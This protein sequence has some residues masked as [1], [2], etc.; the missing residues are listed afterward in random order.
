MLEIPAF[1]YASQSCMVHVPRIA[2]QLHNIVPSSGSCSYPD[3]SLQVSLPPVLEFSTTYPLQIQNFSL[4]LLH[5]PI[6]INCM[7][8]TVLDCSFLTRVGAVTLWDD[9]SPS[10]CLLLTDCLLR[11]NIYDLHHPVYAEIQRSIRIVLDELYHIIVTNTM[12]NCCVKVHA[13]GKETFYILKLCYIHKIILNYIIV[14]IS[15]RILN[16]IRGQRS[17][18]S[19][20]KVI[21]YFIYKCLLPGGGCQD[22]LVRLG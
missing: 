3:L 1:V 6:S 10:D 8:L 12:A 7:G 16:Q 9:P 18:T 2:H 17:V 21:K 15:M 4:Q 5:Q 14:Y 19:S 11:W 13:L 20:S 22:H